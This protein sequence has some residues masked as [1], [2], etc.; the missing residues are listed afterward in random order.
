M[1]EKAAR[2]GARRN[3]GSPHRNTRL[4]TRG[5]ANLKPPAAPSS[6]RGG[7]LVAPRANSVRLLAATRTLLVTS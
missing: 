4:P 1:V 3:A 7:A 6:A 2:L 5:G